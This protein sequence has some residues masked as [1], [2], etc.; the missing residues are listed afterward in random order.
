MSDEL[1]RAPGAV[2]YGTVD[3]S[4]IRD[5]SI[6]AGAKAVYA[7]LTTYASGHDVRAAFP[8][9]ETMAEM[10]GCSTD[11]VDR[12]LTALRKAGVL[13]SHRRQRQTALHFL[14]DMGAERAVGAVDNSPNLD[15]APVPTQPLDSADSG[16]LTPHGRAVDSA[17]ARHKYDQMSNTIENPSLRSGAALPGLESPEPV[18]NP[19]QRINR[20]AQALTRE[21]WDQFDPPP[22][23]PFPGQMSIVKAFLK[24]WTEEQVRAAL[25]QETIPPLTKP[26]LEARLRGGWVGGGRQSTITPVHQWKEGEQWGAK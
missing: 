2:R 4:V 10:L 24:H 13:V 5:P 16:L 25:R 7:L 8:S 20:V 19:D 23:T 18:D 12:G 6:P 1:V 21:W 22:T 15:S 26:R 3:S 14:H 11:T 17:P 9:R